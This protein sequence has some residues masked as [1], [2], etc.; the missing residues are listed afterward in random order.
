MKLLRCIV[1]TAIAS[2]LMATAQ[3]A[4]PMSNGVLPGT[5]NC[6]TTGSNGASTGTVTFMAVTP[7]LVQYHWMT[8]TGKH[9]GNKGGGEWY[10]DA[11]K[12][13]YISLGAGTGFW[14]V[15]R[16]MGSADASTIMLTDT[17]PNDPTNG[18]T[19]FH[20]AQN[21]IS[22]TSDWKEGGKAMH[23]HQV[24]ARA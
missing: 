6:T 13:E 16:G 24:C 19:T 12:G 1:L 10:F 14:G 4:T 5:W 8:K 22:F 18:T 15:S 3:A 9:A 23:A 11:K 21:A 20:F 7:D 2:S 17:Y